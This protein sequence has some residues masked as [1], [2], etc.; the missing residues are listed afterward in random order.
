MH[1]QHASSTCIIINMHQHHHQHA[2]NTD[3][4]HLATHAT[5]V[6]TMAS[7]PKL[8]APRAANPTA[9]R[10][11]TLLWVAEMGR[12]YTVASRVVDPA[13]APSNRKEKAGGKRTKG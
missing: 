13:P 1:H 4:T 5:M 6:F 7:N 10:P 8:A 3:A 12:P 9:T 11:P 2:T